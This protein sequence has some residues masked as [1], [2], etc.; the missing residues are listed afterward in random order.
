MS[1]II[2]LQKK[3]ANNWPLHLLRD[4]NIVLCEQVF[5]ARCALTELQCAYDKLKGDCLFYKR[6]YDRHESMSKEDIKKEYNL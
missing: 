2:D 4:Q 1:E 3:H 5:E 6:Y